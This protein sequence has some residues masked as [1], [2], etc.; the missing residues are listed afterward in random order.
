MGWPD[1]TVIKII[2]TASTMIINR[3]KLVVLLMPIMFYN[4]I[5]QNSKLDSAPDNFKKEKLVAWCIV[6]FHALNRTPRERAEM[7]VDLGLTR[8]A[9]DWR[10]K[11]VTEFEEEILQIVLESGYDGPIGILGHI[12][13]QDV[14]ISLQNNITGLKK[15][16]GE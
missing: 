2:T 7:L 1:Y 16:V 14:A 15:I 10:E 6:P 12:E 9:Y 13:N 3:L 4:S 5:A 11:H 8:V